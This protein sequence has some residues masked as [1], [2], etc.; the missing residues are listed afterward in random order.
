MGSENMH[1]LNHIPFSFWQFVAKFTPETAT[2]S[3]DSEGKEAVL[4][5]PASD[6]SSR[7][8]WY[9]DAA[10]REETASAVRDVIGELRLAGLVAPTGMFIEDREIWEQV[11]ALQLN[12]DQLH[13]G[14][15][16][17]YRDGSTPIAT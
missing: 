17:E 1:F 2:V 11:D 4:I 10:H 7:T 5:P 13:D 14:K 12:D 3:P 9:L 15:L 16:H 8:E 6:R